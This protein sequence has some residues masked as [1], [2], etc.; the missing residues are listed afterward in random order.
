MY[1]ANHLSLIFTVQGKGKKVMM[2]GDTYYRTM[3]IVLW[4]YRDKAQLACD[5]MQLPHHGLCDSGNL[6]FFKTV[7][8]KTLLIPTC[9]A[10]D[11]TMHSDMYGDDPADNNWAEDNAEIVHKSFEGTVEILL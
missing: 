7:N 10:G 1:H 6:E 9:I 4:R 2:T 11:R 5:I 8:A 3:Q